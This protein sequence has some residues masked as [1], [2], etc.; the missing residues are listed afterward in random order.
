MFALQF[1]SAAGHWLFM[2]HCTQATWPPNPRPPRRQ[3][4]VAAGQSL[5]AAHTTH[6]WSC[7]QTGVAVPAQL[8]LVMHCTHVED[9]T[10]QTDLGDEHCESM[11]QPVRQVNVAGLH[12]GAAVPQSELDRQV[13]HWPLDARQRGAAA[14]Q[15]ELL[16]HSTH[17]CMVGSQIFAIA[18]QSAAELQPTQAPVLVLQIGVRPGHDWLFVQAAWQVWVPG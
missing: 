10:S 1:G 3:Y 12:I 11:V 7:E 14:G 13:T 16:A 6:A 18:G 5:L 8:A 9:A 2:R 4:G 17:C 15:S